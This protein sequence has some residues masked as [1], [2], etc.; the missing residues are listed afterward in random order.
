MIAL[1]PF[2]FIDSRTGFLLVI[3]SIA[4]S[5]LPLPHTLFFLSFLPFIH[6]SLP[7]SGKTGLGKI[8]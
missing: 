3:R 6:L 4:F 7:F 8:L 2:S 1:L 5:L